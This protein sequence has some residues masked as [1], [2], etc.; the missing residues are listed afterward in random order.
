MPKLDDDR[1]EAFCLE[2]VKTNNASEAYRRTSKVREG[3]LDASIW[4]QASKQMGDPKV[5]S[6]INEL[7]LEAA[8]S[9]I[10]TVASLTEEL[11][12]ARTMAIE[13]ENAQALQ[14]Q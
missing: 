1:L 9:C 5:I 13:K 14:W 7:Q 11:R 12:E 10:V 3:T 2:Y 6:R 8:E 4:T